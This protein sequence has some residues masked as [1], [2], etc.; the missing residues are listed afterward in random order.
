MY[1]GRR[2]LNGKRIFKEFNLNF[3]HCYFP[4]LKVFF[5]FFNEQS[6]YYGIAFAMNAFTIDLDSPKSNRKVKC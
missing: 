4:V 3:I 5:L 6:S 1:E 2:A